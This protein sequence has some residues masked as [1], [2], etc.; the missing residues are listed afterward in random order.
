[1]GLL[2]ALESEG[3]TI[4]IDGD[5]T[6]Y[7]A[8]TVSGVPSS[9]ADIVESDSGIR[10]R[11]EYLDREGNPVDVSGLEQNDVIIVHITVAPEAENLKNVIIVDMLPAGLEIE[12]PRLGRDVHLDWTDPQTLTPDYMDICDDRMILFASFSDTGE[13]H[14]YYAARAVTVGSFTLPPIKAEC[15]YDPAIN[16]TSGAGKIVVK[17]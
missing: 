8:L 10:V 12:N 3:V 11:R 2:T 7:Y 5:G 13:Y 1:M 4:S 16:S 17:E 9:T 6:A 14:F 15:M